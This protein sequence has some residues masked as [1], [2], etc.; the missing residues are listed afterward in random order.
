LRRLVLTF[1]LFCGAI[2][3]AQQVAIIDLTNQPSYADIPKAHM[4]E[5]RAGCPDGIRF[6]S[7]NEQ[8][9][10][11]GEKLD[12][13][14][15]SLDRKSVHLNEQLVATVQL[16]NA[17]TKPSLIP[18]N[19]VRPA[20]PP[21]GTFTRRYA[22]LGIELRGKGLYGLLPYMATMAFY[23]DDN[24]HSLVLKP[25]EW[26]QVRFRTVFD[27]GG[28]ICEKIAPGDSIEVIATWSEI[29]QAMDRSGCTTLSA[30]NTIRSLKSAP[31]PLKVLDA[32]PSAT[33]ENQ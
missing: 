1:A 11:P 30:T 24:E 10:D 22:H 12:F 17:G 21:T 3:P 23:K 32:P 15:V 4:P 19:S 33:K 13:S 6:A 27:C 20:T 8:R 5:Q 25:G 9:H 16:L 26:V 14:L 7:K 18:W 2:C 28:G 29:E 31:M